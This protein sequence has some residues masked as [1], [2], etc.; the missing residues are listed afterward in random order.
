MYNPRLLSLLLTITY[1][2]QAIF[3]AGLEP[4]V[5]VRSPVNGARRAV[6]LPVLL[7]AVLAPVQDDR[8]KTVDG[9]PAGFWI[10]G[11]ISNARLARVSSSAASLLVPTS[12]PTMSCGLPAP[13]RF[14]A[15][16]WSQVRARLAVLPS[17]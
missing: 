4:C 6:I 8:S 15:R 1:R 17:S 7:L 10:A 11:G 2:L 9:I 3:S 12:R 16:E 14:R 5:Q 13:K